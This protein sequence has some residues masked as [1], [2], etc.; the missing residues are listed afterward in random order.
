MLPHIMALKSWPLAQLEASMLNVAGGKK[1][2]DAEPDPNAE[3]ARPE[4]Q[5]RARELLMPWAH[6][7]GPD[8]RL[9]EA[10]TTTGD[11]SPAEAPEADPW[12][13]EG[14][15]AFLYAGS[16]YAAP[17]VLNLVTKPLEKRLQSLASKA[18]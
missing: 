3:P 18:T 2:P 10:L 7:V 16:R 6:L 1:D 13:P 14:A 4:L 9:I 15:E 12:T 17:W 11:D 8:A 5:F